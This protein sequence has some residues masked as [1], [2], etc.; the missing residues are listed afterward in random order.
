MIKATLRQARSRVTRRSIVEAAERL[1]KDQPFDDVPVTQICEAAGV[2]KGSFYFHFPRK[3]HLLV[4]LMFERFLPREKELGGYLDSDVS[5]ADVFAALVTGI[6]SRVRKLDKTLVLRA[7]EESF[8]HYR[9]IGKLPGGD[10]SLS[11]YFRS[12]F[13]RGRHRGEVDRGWDPDT[14]ASALGWVVLQALMLWG[15][16]SVADKE[17]TANLIQRAELVSSGAAARR[18]PAKAAKAKPVAS[19]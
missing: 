9:E 15:G 5:T 14:L 3:E 19:G 1:W 13:I 12:V 17:L 6:A 16:G 11:W 7:V 10:R 8:Q 18:R 4:M 2:A